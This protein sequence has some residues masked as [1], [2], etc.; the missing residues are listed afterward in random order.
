MPRRRMQQTFKLAAGVGFFDE[1][2]V[3]PDG[4]DPQLTMS[5]ADRP[6]ALWTAFPSI[7]R[8]PLASTCVG[9]DRRANPMG[10]ISSKEACECPGCSCRPAQVFVNFD[11]APEVETPDRNMLGKSTALFQTP[12]RRC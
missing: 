4:V 3:L 9:R 1:Y 12:D 5:R 6:H 10:R 11:H 2:P 7:D 8:A